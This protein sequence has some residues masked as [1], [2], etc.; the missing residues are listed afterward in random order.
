MRI[1]RPLDTASMGLMELYS[2]SGIRL[3]SSP[4]NRVTALIPRIVFS[5]PG[6]ARTLEP[7]GNFTV[8]LVSL[9]R[10]RTSGSISRKSRNLIINSWLCL[11]LGES[12]TI[13]LLGILIASCKASAA[14]VV[15]LPDC[16]E[17]FRIIRFALLLRK[18]SCQGSG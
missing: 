6:S 1:K 3:A 11:K 4:T 8:S 17:Q 10:V 2:G 5:E 12:R 9:S 13:T 18:R 15:D 16:L 14:V 7:F